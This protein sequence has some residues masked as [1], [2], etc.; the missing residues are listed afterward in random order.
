MYSYFWR[1]KA[2]TIA[3]A[4]VLG[5]SLLL[6]APLVCN[7]A[8]NDI[9]QVSEIES[10]VRITGV[11]PSP[12]AADN[13]L[14]FL[15]GQSIY[16]GSLRSISKAQRTT[17]PLYCSNDFGKTWK[18]V[19]I[20]KNDT[21]MTEAIGV[22][23]IG[24][25]QDGSVMVTVYKQ[26]VETT[27]Q[28]SDGIQWTKL[29][30]AANLA[31]SVD[32]CVPSGLP[33][34]SVLRQQ[35]NNTQWIGKN[36]VWFDGSS[37]QLSKDGGKKWDKLFTGVTPGYVVDENTMLGVDYNAGLT[38]YHLNGNKELVTLNVSPQN[39]DLGGAGSLIAVVESDGSRTYVYYNSGY[40]SNPHVDI[41]PYIFYSR[42]NGQSWTQVN[43][44]AFDYQAA[45]GSKAVT[46]L[47]AAP[48]GFIA[49]TTNDNRLHL[50]YDYGEKWANRS[51]TNISRHFIN[52]LSSNDSALIYVGDKSWTRVVEA[53]KTMLYNSELACLMPEYA[54][55]DIKREYCL[56]Y[57][58]KPPVT[59]DDAVTVTQSAV[60]KNKAVPKPIP[61]KPIKPALPKKAAGTT[62][63]VK[64]K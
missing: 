63:A 36:L 21:S 31:L 61:T 55:E 59:Q 20:D 3:K 34:K 4:M 60:I 40:K 27:W 45:I 38:R 56:Y 54:S 53:G 7:A 39:T 49:L 11:Y 58:E 25:L 37:I 13:H 33:T 8:S 35:Y 17:Y 42:D 44:K 26:K 24:F 22:K 48:G 5:L 52:C 30:D 51:T 46:S 50:L 57:F 2:R 12:R 43:M 16:K 18:N 14:V 19:D 29:S 47:S 32:Q 64:K 41:Q 15:T 62:K 6:T 23:D 10:D 1:K 28:S 9:V